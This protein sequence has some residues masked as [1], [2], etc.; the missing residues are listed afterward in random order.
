MAGSIKLLGIY[1][2]AV[3]E[4]LLKQQTLELW[5]ATPSPSQQAQVRDQLGSV[6]LV[7]VLVTDADEKFGAP[8]FTQEDPGQPRANWQAAWDVSFL[9]ADGEKLLAKRL[10]SLS[11]RTTN[12]RVAFYI[13][14]WKSGQPLITSY[15]ALSTPPPSPMPERLSRLVPFASV[16]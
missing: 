10:K 4:D 8:D 3:S 15:G 6:V 12:F 2:L 13:H 11:P 14:Y 5:G 9:S 7:E 16:D 1:T